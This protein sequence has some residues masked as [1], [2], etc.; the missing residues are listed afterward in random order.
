[1]SSAAYVLCANFERA[2][3]INRHGSVAVIRETLMTEESK[4]KDRSVYVAT[5]HTCT[6]IKIAQPVSWG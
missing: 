2:K 5:S 6:C 1:M 4:G 3:V